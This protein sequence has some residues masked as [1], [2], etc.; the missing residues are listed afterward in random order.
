MNFPKSFFFAENL[1]KY[2][3]KRTPNIIIELFKEQDV[4]HVLTMTLQ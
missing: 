2:K 1:I 3:I 4:D